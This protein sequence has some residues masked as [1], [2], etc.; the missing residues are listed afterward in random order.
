MST[1]NNTG[2]L[3]NTPT[4]SSNAP[5][6]QSQ[7]PGTIVES[8]SRSTVGGGVWYVNSGE[9]SQSFS[10]ESPD[11]NM[12]VTD[13]VNNWLDN[14]ISNNGLILKWSGSQEDSTDYSG[15]I[16][17]FSADANSIYSPKIE[18]RWDD[19]TDGN[20]YAV[21][22]DDTNDYVDF[23]DISDIN[24]A[25]AMTISAWVYLKTS[26]GH[27]IL[28]KGNY[29]GADSS[30]Y[31]GINTSA[32]QSNF[33]ISNTD[34]AHPTVTVSLNTWT[35]LAIVY[36]KINKRIEWYKNGVSQYTENGSFWHNDNYVSIT[37]SANPVRVGNNAT[38]NSGMTGLTDE[39]A[40]FNVAKTDAEILAI[41][42]Q[43]TPSNLASDTGLIGYWRFEEG[44]G[45]T[46]ED[47]SSNSWNGTLTNDPTWVTSTLGYSNAAQTQILDGT[48]DV[49]VY[50]KGLR[51]TY[52]ETETP[53][54][55]LGIRDRYITKSASTSK[56]TNL[57]KYLPSAK[58]WY[59]MVDVE[60]GETLIPFGDNSKIGA[61]SI[62]SYFKLNFK[63]F[64]V[65]RLYRILIR[66]QLDDGR[67]RIFDDNFNFKVVS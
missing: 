67:Y 19:T 15:D 49:Y 55:R 64:I 30:F 44:T 4:W 56:S 6:S 13:I 17:F 16:N 10:Y 57:S 50:M 54:I 45:T 1:Y 36:D 14:S 41:Y 43:G 37:P 33:S 12:D 58:S 46:V 48:T 26:A 53:K 20:D 8:G 34:Y 66:I 5:H 61:D 9:C 65:N 59:S 27:T 28:S 23:G 21:E 47:L 35:H 22:F 51:E 29:N 40:L 32:N 31:W 11:V 25:D 7:N 63:G 18:V 42:N 39:L 52:R 62:S 2:S 38:Q 24:G 60:T 3:E